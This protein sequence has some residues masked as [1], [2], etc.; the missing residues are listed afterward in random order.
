MKVVAH[1]LI[2]A[3]ALGLLAPTALATEREEDRTKRECRE[4]AVLADDEAE[5]FTEILSGTK[6]PE[7]V[8]L[9]LD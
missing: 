6:F 7:V 3:V 8:S 2:V 1:P 9:T 4:A 5:S